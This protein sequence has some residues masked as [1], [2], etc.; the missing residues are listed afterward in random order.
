[1]PLGV[2]PRV[3]QGG[4]GLVV[5]RSGAGLITLP[6]D[7]IASS[8]VERQVNIAVSADLTCGGSVEE[9]SFG[10]RGATSH[11]ERRG[12]RTDLW[13]R[14]LEKA[15][16]QSIPAARLTEVR[17]QWDPAASTFAITWAFAG[18]RSGAAAAGGGRYLS[19]FLIDVT[20]P[21]EPWRAE[22]AGSIWVA[23]T[24]LRETVRIKPPAGWS[25]A[26][27][28]TAFLEELDGARAS[29]TYT[30]E[31]DEIIGVREVALPGG[32]FDR[33]GYESARALTKRIANA[34]RRPIL[35]KKL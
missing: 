25:V 4:H 10:T 26:E 6:Q 3:D 29:V 12:K 15:L 34:E 17:D 13:R 2:L 22:T 28:P 8:R 20:E 27:V 24:S 9:K 19:P 35:L 32:L 1:V 30:R 31:G 11:A 33:R 18:G 14:R 16:A 7:T 5:G 23:P 21:L